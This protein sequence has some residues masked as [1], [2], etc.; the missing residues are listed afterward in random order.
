M[1]TYFLVHD[2]LSTND[3]GVVRGIRFFRRYGRGLVSKPL[4]LLIKI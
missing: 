1:F 4:I 2:G 3:V